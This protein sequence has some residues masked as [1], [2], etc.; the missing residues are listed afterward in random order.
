MP[1]VVRPLGTLAA[2]GVRHRHPRLKRASLAWVEGPILRHAAFV[3]CTSQSELLEARALGIAFRG[4][5]IPLGVE[6]SL[7]S[8]RV[9]DRWPAG[10]RGTGRIVLYLSRID[11][12]KNLEGLLRAFAMVAPSRPDVTLRIAGDGPTAYVAGLK[13]LASALSIADRVAWLGHV[14]GDAKRTALATADVFALPS[15][16]ENFGIAVVEAML[17]GLPCILGHGVGIAAQAREAGACLVVAPEPDAIAAALAQSLDDDTGRRRMGERGRA[18]AQREYS[19]ATMAARLMDLYLDL[20]SR[21]GRPD[22]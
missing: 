21:R 4:G 20:T 9:A 16:S 2:Y 1:Y 12:K 5:V 11:P 22:A 15:L 8:V 6:P 18:L 7:E 19:T 10:P 3:H 13:A 14:D 17:A